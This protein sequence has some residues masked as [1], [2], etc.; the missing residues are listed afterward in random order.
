[1]PNPRATMDSCTGCILHN[2]RTFSLN[3]RIND[4][5]WIVRSLAL[6][7]SL[8]HL[9]FVQTKDWPTVLGFLDEISFVFWGLMVVCPWYVHF[10]L[11]FCIITWQNMLMVLGEVH[12]LDPL[13]TNL[14]IHD[15]SW[16]TRSGCVRKIAY[17]V[18]WPF[19]SSSLGKTCSE[20]H[21]RRI[22]VRYDVQR[23]VHKEFLNSHF[24]SKGQSCSC[25][26]SWQRDICFLT[27]WFGERDRVWQ[28]WHWVVEVL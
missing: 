22:L 3:Y 19:R 2:S 16:I 15:S 14:L 25:W 12:L 5:P 27:C 21:C 4:S 13:L 10:W 11:I 7:H 23:R 24:S 9:W 20:L 1:M 26:M 8:T 6:I 18:S 17:S 28:S